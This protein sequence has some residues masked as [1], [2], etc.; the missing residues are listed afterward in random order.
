VLNQ[1]KTLSA[2]LFCYFLLGRKQSRLQI[3]SLIL[4][5][6]AGLIIEKVL[7]LPSLQR[8]LRST[9]SIKEHE[10]SSQTG[11]NPTS[12]WAPSPA[13]S[14]QSPVNSANVRNSVS[15]DSTH[16]HLTKGV[17]P[18]LLASLIS[19]LAGALSQKALQI[20]DRNSYLFSMELSA[21]SLLVL[22]ASLLFG[23]PDGQRL[24]RRTESAVNEN[25][26]DRLWQGWTWRTWTPIITNAL[27]GVLVGLVTK[28]CGSVR[29]GFALIFGL[30]LSGILQSNLSQRKKGGDYANDPGGVSKEQVVGGCLAAISL[31]IHSNFPHTP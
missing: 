10:L 15:D 23:S 21:A 24:F 26:T 8:S 14:L 7:P 9:Q 25:W 29:K 2:A 11:A 4:L 27:G 28:Y 13:L 18:V 3:F 30:L 6:A 17:I 19:G 5:L 31:W 16:A 22:I 1:T 12:S 20:W